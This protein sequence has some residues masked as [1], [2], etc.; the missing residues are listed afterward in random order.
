V[1]GDEDGVGTLYL[2]SETGGTGRDV[3]LTEPEVRD[4]LHGLLMEWIETSRRLVDF[5]ESQGET[6]LDD[7]PEEFKRQLEA[8][9][10]VDPSP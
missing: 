10:Y 8:L 2:L 9:G 7:F 3:T 6:H 1:Y 5:S 4:R